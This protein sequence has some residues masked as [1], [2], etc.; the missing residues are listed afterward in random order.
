[1]HP[2]SDDDSVSEE[3]EEWSQS[4]EEVDE[5]TELGNLYTG[6]TQT[7]YMEPQENEH[8][9]IAHSYNYFEQTSNEF[10]Q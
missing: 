5:V 10:R 6:L 3:A 9:S 2:V 4:N 7:R 8:Q 1:M